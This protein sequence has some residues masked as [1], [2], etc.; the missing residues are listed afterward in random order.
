[1]KY[2]KKLLKMVWLIIEVLFKSIIFILES[3][4]TEIQA[5]KGRG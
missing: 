4:V 1:M 2:L 3:I 5:S